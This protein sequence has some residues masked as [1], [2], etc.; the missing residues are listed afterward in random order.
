MF[1]LYKYTSKYIE[2]GYPDKNPDDKKTQFLNFLKSKDIKVQMFHGTSDISYMMAK[3]SGWFSPS[4]WRGT[5]KNQARF[6]RVDPIDQLGT[7]KGLNKLFFTKNIYTAWTYAEKEANDWN[8]Y[9]KKARE[10]MGITMEA[11]PIIIDAMIPLSYF[12]EI[13][14]NIAETPIYNEKRYDRIFNQII[15][16]D[17][18]NE[19]KLTML[20]NEIQ[21]S[22]FR[23][24]EFSIKSALPFK[25]EGGFEFIKTLG[26]ED[27]KLEKIKLNPRVYNEDDE[28][29]KDPKFYEA[30]LTGWENL[31]KY[32]PE[33]Y[34]NLPDEV[35][36]SN[37]SRYEDA[38]K[39]G[40]AYGIEGDVR[41]IPSTDPSIM[42]SDPELFNKSK[43]RGWLIA[44]YN[45]PELLKKLPLEYQ[46]DIQKF[47]LAAVDGWG[48]QMMKDPSKWA[49][50]D[51]ALKDKYKD[52]LSRMA[53]NC[54]ATIIRRNPDMFDSVPQDI[55]SFDSDTLIKAKNFKNTFNM[56]KNEV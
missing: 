22:S 43:E 55:M 20:L 12:D 11:K 47:E 40:L 14:G 8:T 56:S 18:S 30:Y 51:S 32:N 41:K 44:L 13:K 39:K 42:S 6:Q 27:V 17:K 2:H 16:S 24:N 48:R 33:E 5:H 7:T 19:E 4:T 28:T 49:Y 23:R 26:D 31:I 46:E 50:I 45:Y 25:R 10:D 21:E 34:K 15:D 54:W 29:Q 53:V 3:K 38:Y 1:N 9:N 36:S 52:K 37:P 35:K